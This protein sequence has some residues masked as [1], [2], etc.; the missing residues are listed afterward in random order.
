[1]KIKN[2]NVFMYIVKILFI[3]IY[4]FSVVGCNSTTKSKNTSENIEQVEENAS[5]IKIES[6]EE[7][8]DS[9]PSVKSENTIKSAIPK[10]SKE[11]VLTEDRTIVKPTKQ[12]V[13][14]ADE[15]TQTPSESKTLTYAA[16]STINLV[17][18]MKLAP[19]PTVNLFNSDTTPLVASQIPNLLPDYESIIYVNNTI[20]TSDTEMLD[21]IIR[22]SELNNVD[23]NTSS[24]SFSIVKNINMIL[25]FDQNETVHKGAVVNNAKWSMSETLTSYRFTYTGD[26]FAG[27][28]LSKVGLSA[29]Y[30][31][32]H[33]ARGYFAFY[34]HML[35]GSSD[36]NNDNDED[37][38][39]IMYS[40]LKDMD[41]PVI[42]LNGESNMTLVVDHNYTEFGATAVDHWDDSSVAVDINGSVNTSVIGTYMI[43]YTATDNAGFSSSTIRIVHVV[44]AIENNAPIGIDD[45]YTTNKNVSILL[46]VLANDTDADDDNLTVT[47]LG[48][49]M[50]GSVVVEQN[51]VRYTPDTGYFGEDSFTYTAFDNID[52]SNSTTVTI[53]VADVNASPVAVADVKVGIENEVLTIDV[54]ENDLNNSTDIDSGSITFGNT[55]LHGTLLLSES[56]QVLYTPATNFT[57]RDDFTYTVKNTSQNVSNEANVTVYIAAKNGSTDIDDDNVSDIIELKFGSDPLVSGTDIGIDDSQKDMLHKLSRIT[58]GIN[59]E[60]L[61]DVEQKGGFDAW[62]ANQLTTQTIPPLGTFDE[63]DYPAQY[64]RDNYHMQNYTGVEVPATIRPLHSKRYLQSVMETFWDNH[65]NTELTDGSMATNE[66]YEADSFYDHAF[67]GFETLLTLSAQSPLMSLYLNGYQNTKDGPNENYAREV[68]ELHTVGLDNYSN[69]DIV[70]L[71]RIFT[72][73]TYYFDANN[74][75]LSRYTKAKDDPY[76]IDE[77]IYQ[78]KFNA[79]NHDTGADKIF[80]GQTIPTQSGENGVQEGLEALHILATHP[81]TAEFICTKLARKFVSDNPEPATIQACKTTFLNNT[82][83]SDQIKKVLMTLFDSAEFNNPATYINKAKDDQEYL[84]SFARAVSVDATRYEGTSVD[85]YSNLGWAL[86]EGRLKQPFYRKAEPTGYYETSKHWIKG[87]SLH[88]RMVESNRIIERF[89]SL[90]LVNYFKSLNLQ[91]GT[92]II[93]HLISVCMNGYYRDSEL[94]LLYDTLYTNNN[95]FDIDASD[96]ESK[97]KVLLHMIALMPKTHLQ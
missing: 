42:T 4:L 37:S 41:S 82:Q 33:Y 31:A 62:L 60:I 61:N 89:E 57:G 81:K 53:M 10:P 11:E 92:D 43:T 40:N 93:R 39:T 67:G 35:N 19:T 25:Y 16:G 30:H 74:K 87:D 49:A 21:I 38:D 20:I 47:N 2:L 63:A 65:F 13:S 68:M 78:F 95:D 7:K 79:A 28:T 66:L 69:Q 56:N 96:A 23:N 36:A 3:S 9:S 59:A 50:H 5:S 34:V 6:I 64:K 32:P 24:V 18:D 22:I 76:K 91:E 14:V 90:H 72:G 52:E 8:I 77:I 44:E 54:L 71:A 83:A 46:D 1:M 55:P 58:W 48:T 29:R 27:Q 94:T 17:S 12:E 88:R 73:W 97:L 15:V 26:V 51:K 70:E 80:L 86:S 85:G 75:I 45:A 84:L